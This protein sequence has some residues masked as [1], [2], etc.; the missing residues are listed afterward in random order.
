MEQGS[1]LHNF[2]STFRGISGDDWRKHGILFFL[3]FFSTTLTGVTFALTQENVLLQGLAYSIPVMIILTGHELGHYYFARKYGVK[4]SLPF[5]IPLPLISPFGTLGAFIKMETFPESRREL[6][7][8]AFWGPAMS[9]LL[10]IPFAVT[11]LLLSRVQAIPADFTGV[12]FGDSLIFKFIAGMFFDIPEGHDIIIHP[13]AFAAWVG[14]FVT[15][16]NLIPVGQLD[17]GHIA[18]SLFGK[19][20]KEIA[21]TSL[22]ILGIM[23]LEFYGWLVWL[24]LL[25]AMGIKHPPLFSMNPFHD[26]LDNR[27]LKL[28]W[29][30]LLMLLLCF[31]PAPMK[32]ES[33][34]P[35]QQEER[36]LPLSDEFKVQLEKFTG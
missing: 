7:D 19:R 2:L 26:F 34:Q 33:P 12:V 32:Q 31:T 14:F 22:V 16:I 21:V 20:Q 30:S 13:M 5:F 29:G 15:A 36:K 27:R 23:A 18:Y 28:A 24:V 25:V 6:F 9:F 4:V 10:S 11:G 8:I 3:T 35:G 17:G 1:R